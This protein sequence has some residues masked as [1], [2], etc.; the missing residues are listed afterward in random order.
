ME[1]GQAEESDA[2]AVP[3]RAV[4]DP[5][6]DDEQ[7]LEAGENGTVR[8]DRRLR[9]GRRAGGED[10]D[11]RIVLV[12]SERRIVPDP[13]RRRDHPLDISE[14][15]GRRAGGDPAGTPLVDE[16]EAGGDRLECVGYL[17]GAPP[18]VPQHGN[19]AGPHDGP[20]RD[21]KLDGIRPED[22]DR[23]AWP[24]PML[25]EVATD[26]SDG[27]GVGIEGQAPPALNEVCPLTVRGRVLEEITDMPPTVGEDLARH[28]E[29]LLLHQFVAPGRAGLEL[30]FHCPTRRRRGS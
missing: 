18:G 23:V 10:H 28:S 8:E 7:A 25:L 19:A 13:A 5:T 29:H 9:E 24:D 17:G 22:D 15:Q 30:D 1:Q 3:R 16:H 20:D 21:D 27:S 2:A 6:G 14:A 4:R 11:R 12:P 26:G